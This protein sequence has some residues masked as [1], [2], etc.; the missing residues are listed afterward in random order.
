M[1]VGCLFQSAQRVFPWGVPTEVGASDW[2]PRG[3]P[4]TTGRPS[5]AAGALTPSRRETIAQLTAATLQSQSELSAFA[6]TA[7][8]A[9]PGQPHAALEEVHVRDA[10]RGAVL[11]VHEEVPSA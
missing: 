10:R 7:T 2:G 11:S 1:G 3:V 6:R 5:P 4:L 9:G 8:E